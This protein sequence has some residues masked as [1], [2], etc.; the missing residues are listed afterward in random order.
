MEI[1]DYGAG[2]SGM[3]GY[4]G[5]ISSIG[6]HIITSAQDAQ[7]MI[8]EGDNINTTAPAQQTDQFGKPVYNLGNFLKETSSID[9]SGASWEEVLSGAVKG[10]EAGASAGPWG[11]L[12]GGVHGIWTTLAGGNERKN[13]QRIRKRQAMQ[14]LQAAQRIY[15]QGIQSYNAR[16]SA[17]SLY[18]SM[19]QQEQD[20]ANNVYQA[21]S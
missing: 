21:L 5:A 16:Q 13:L 3:G 17:Q 12:F 19:L 18:G 4:G 11:A 8:D 14:N 6:G 7:K 10:V 20:R 2:A 9:P 1:T 15:N